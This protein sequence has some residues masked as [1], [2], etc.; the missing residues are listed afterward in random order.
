M[1]AQL[2]DGALGM[3]Y[4]V[5][6]A[7]LLLGLGVPPAL[8]SAS[9]HNAEVFTCGASGFS[10]WLAG[11]VR[12]PLFLAL[13]VPGVV[14]AVLGA[15][16]VSRVPPTWMRIALTPYLLAI[17]AFLLLRAWRGGSSDDGTE[18]PRV[19]GPLGFIAGFVDA[20]GGGG[21]SALTV[22]AL[23]ARGAP[24][25]RVIGSVHAAKF[26][27]SI[28]ASLI[29]LAGVGGAHG[30]AVLGLIVGGVVAAP[31]GAL[32]ARRLPARV[33][34]VLAGCTVFGLGLRNVL[35]VVG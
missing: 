22:T 26:V 2:V 25:R 16:V 9:V 31:I 11:N 13:V 6:S 19:S 28:A 5:T 33:A 18:V 27:V 32:F 3:A 8:A 29:F 15:Q 12:R 20:I 23:V 30:D 35:S 14:G 17:G 10:H 7:A 34:T 21:W 24:P 1:L 4:G